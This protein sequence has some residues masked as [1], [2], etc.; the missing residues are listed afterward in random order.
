MK[1]GISGRFRAA[2]LPLRMFARSII[3]GVV[4]V[5]TLALFSCER[6]NP[7][8]S[9]IEGNYATGQGHYQEAT[10]HY[11][12]A[13]DADT[14]PARV[15]YDLANVYHS[16]GE[17]EAALDLW[18]KASNTK[19]SA[20]LFALSYNEGVQYYELGKYDD[21]YNSFRSALTYD[22]SSMNAKVNLELALRKIQGTQSPAENSSSPPKD[23]TAA[24]NQMSDQEATRVLEYVRRKEEQQWVPSQQQPPAASVEDW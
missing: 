21:A 24:N 6:S 14:D 16:L 3:G 10:V 5:A 22:P 13:L 1:R 23:Q 7:Y 2:R 8:I 12:N 11:L 9:V 18:K 20:L 4:V 17:A 19:D 15:S